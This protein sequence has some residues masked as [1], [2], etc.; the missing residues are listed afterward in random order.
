MPRPLPP[1]P[2]VNAAPLP[3]VRLP[4]SN[5]PPQ[6]QLALCDVA[7]LPAGNTV[8]A[9]PPSPQDLI[10]RIHADD[11]S[12]CRMMAH[13]RGTHTPA[14]TAD[15]QA[16]IDGLAGRRVLLARA[17]ADDL[18]RWSQHVDAAPFGPHLQ[19]RI[20]CAGLDQILVALQRAAL[21]ASQRLRIGEALRDAGARTAAVRAGLN[22]SH[23]ELELV[24]A[25][26]LL[27][28]LM[29]TRRAAALQLEALTANPMTAAREGRDPNRA[30]LRV[31]RATAYQ[32]A[33]MVSRRFGYETRRPTWTFIQTHTTRENRARA[34]QLAILSKTPEA[35]R[36]G[37]TLALP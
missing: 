37:I 36:L 6:S 27:D 5:A 14:R 21:S 9:A 1:T 31:A 8:T 34:R 25:D 3:P 23:A 18:Y 33:A 24:R 10:A 4:R 17:T 12:L 7:N 13:G 28:R 35:K 15:A 19:D 29:P 20:E 26:A 16:I 32:Q 11:L 22:L 2:P 30:A